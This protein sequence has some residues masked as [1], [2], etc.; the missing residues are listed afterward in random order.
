M[1]KI[2]V[3]EDAAAAPVKTKVI[4]TRVPEGLVSEFNLFCEEAK[5]AGKSV[6]LTKSIIA[7][8]ENMI[9][10]GR[11]QLQAAPNQQLRKQKRLCRKQKH[12][13]TK[14]PPNIDGRLYL[15]VCGFCRDTNG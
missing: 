2:P 11:K 12:V 4:S 9:K 15:V 14:R 5:K 6:N 1:A 3:F 13:N 10:D 7:L 8:M